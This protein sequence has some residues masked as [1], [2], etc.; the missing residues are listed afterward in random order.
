MTFKAKIEKRTVKLMTY[1]EIQ[2]KKGI[3]VHVAYKK[4]N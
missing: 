3:K 1:V 2:L 4:P